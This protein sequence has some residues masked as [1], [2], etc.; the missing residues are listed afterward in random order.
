MQGRNVS[1]SALTRRSEERCSAKASNG[2]RQVD[3]VFL[4]GEGV[5]RIDA[6]VEGS[7]ASDV[8][9]RLREGGRDFPVGANGSSTSGRS[10]AV[11]FLGHCWRHL[12][13]AALGSSP[14]LCARR[15]HLVEDH[16]HSMDLLQVVWALVGV[17]NGLS[18][19]KTSFSPGNTF[20]LP[21]YSLLAI[22]S[23][24]SS[25]AAILVISLCSF[26]I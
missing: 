2:L 25:P 18:F 11:D 9:W 12:S 19:L 14:S 26:K 24:L 8:E 21:S 17:R 23:H 6:A 20:I 3:P 1:P 13:P 7:P 4:H 5:E 22:V 16:W 10:T 15:W